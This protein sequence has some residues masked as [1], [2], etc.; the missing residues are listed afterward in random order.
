M[1]SLALDL[2]KTDAVTLAAGL[3]LCVLAHAVA[4]SWRRNHAKCRC[5][6]LALGDHVRPMDYDAKTYLSQGE[7][8]PGRCR[9]CLCRQPIL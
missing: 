5:G 6:H 7:Y 2:L 9:K 1:D 3:G 8:E 4:D